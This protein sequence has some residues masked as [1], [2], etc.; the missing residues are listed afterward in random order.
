MLFS[1]NYLS[2]LQWLHAKADRPR[3][4]GGKIKPLGTF[5][6]YFELWKPNSVI[7]YG[8]G[9]GVIL[10]HLKT[11]FPDTVW[12]GYDPAVNEYKNIIDKTYDC[13]FSTDVLEHIEPQFLDN[14]LDHMWN[15]SNKFLWLRIDTRPA[16]KTLQDGR[17][18]HLILEDK[19]WWENKLKERPGKIVYI[20]L[21][22]KGKL[23]VAIEK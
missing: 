13:V 9:K 2:E 22:K 5:Y 14:V 3:G 7:D 19:S 6:T 8:C 17:N 20:E 12:H 18:A 4:F 21:G 15:L 11:N 16:R 1:N 23:D 10:N